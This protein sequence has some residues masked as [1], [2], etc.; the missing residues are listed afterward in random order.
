MPES[1]PACIACGVFKRELE[2]LA[3]KGLIDLE[4]QTLESML[5]M[6]PLKLEKVLGQLLS[7]HPEKK[8]ILIYG[9]CQPRMNELESRSGVSRTRGVNCCEILLGKNAYR[10]L[11]HEKAFVFL[12]EWAVRWREIF[13]RE[14]GFAKPENACCFLKEYLE[15]LVF[16]DTGVVPVSEELLHEIRD[17]FD[18]PLEIIKISLDNLKGAIE[19]AVL[20]LNGADSS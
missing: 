5:H 4:V 13:A 11:Q 15:K 17:Y 10:K 19:Q 8:Y 18:M 1:T 12:P 20:K 2:A 9:D 7:Q 16:I 6:D 3:G 14:L